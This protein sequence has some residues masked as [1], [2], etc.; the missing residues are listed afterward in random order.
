MRLHLS[1]SADLT[2]LAPGAE[3]DLPP[4][5]SRHLQVLRAQPGDTVECFDGAGLA[6]TVHVLRMGRQQVRVRV[7][8]LLPPLANELPERLGVAVGMPANDR[9]DGL[10]E[11][12]VELGVAAIQP[13]VCERSV[14]RLAGERAERKVLHWQAVAAG[15]AEQS[16]RRVVPTVALVRTLPDWLA[17]LATP[18]APHALLTAPRPAAS[19]GAPDGNALVRSAAPSALGDAAASPG[20]T[21]PPLRWALSGPEGGLTDAEEA[22]ARRHGFADCSLGPRV[23]RADTAPLVWLAVEGLRGRA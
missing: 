20:A 11:K 14:L 6:W 12:A 3:L 2:R 21:P 18:G 5:A 4:A 13:L 1:A 23:L 10:V 9:M 7:A 8:S 17:T 15:A 22:A 16:G 19:R